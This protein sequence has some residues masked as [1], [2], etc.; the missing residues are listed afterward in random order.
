MSIGRVHAFETDGEY[1][2]YFP[3]TFIDWNTSFRVT[4]TFRRFAY[5]YIFGGI[6]MYISRIRII[7][8]CD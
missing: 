6:F 4:R 8:E 2:E 7:R 5:T 3:L 1:G